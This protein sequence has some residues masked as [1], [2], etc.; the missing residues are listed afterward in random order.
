MPVAVTENAAVW[1]TA[2]VWLAGCAVITGA[3]LLFIG[4][5]LPLLLLPPQ[6]GR[7]SKRAITTE[8][9]SSS[10]QRRI[11]TLMQQVRCGLIRE[12]LLNTANNGQFWKHLCW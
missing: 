3:E 12:F 5:E 1:P 6:P 8:T 9:S 4:P 10:V 7:I 2:T 11:T